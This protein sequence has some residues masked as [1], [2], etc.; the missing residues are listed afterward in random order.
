MAPTPNPFPPHQTTLAQ[1]TVLNGLLRL[2]VE[3]MVLEDLLARALD[4]ILAIP[5]LPLNPT[6]AIFLTGEEPDILELAVERNLPPELKNRCSRVPF[7]HCLCGRAAAMRTTQFAACIDHRHETTYPGIFPHGHY[8]LPLLQGERLLGVLTLYLPEGHIP[9]E[10]E[11][12]FLEAVANAVAKLIAHVRVEEELVAAMERA[13][14]ASRTRSAFL[15]V[16]T[17]EIRTPLNGVLGMLDLLLH[18]DLTGDQAD[19]VRVARN[20]ATTLLTLLDDCLA[21]ARAKGERVESRRCTFDPIEVVATALEVVAPVAMEKELSLAA[22]AAG[23]LPKTVVGDGARLRQLLIHLLSNAVKFT[24]RRDEVVVELECRHVSGDI[25]LEVAVRDTG[26]GM[27]PDRIPHLFE[28]FVQADSSSTRRHGGSGLGLALCHTLVAQMGGKIGV[29]S[30]LG[31]GTTIRCS[32]PVAHPTPPVPVPPRLHAAS[33]LV[34]PATS[35]TTTM[36]V[37]QLRRWGVTVVWASSLERALMVVEQGGRIGR[38]TTILIVDRDHTPDLMSLYTGLAALPAASRPVVLEIG[39]AG[40]AARSMEPPPDL[41]LQ[42]LQKPLQPVVLHRSLA[43]LLDGWENVVP[44]PTAAED[45]ASSESARI[46]VAE[47]NQ[48][49]QQVL[50]HLVRQLGHEVVVVSNGAEAVAAVADGGI[51]LVLMDH[52]MPVMAG[53][54]A[55]ARIRATEPPGRRT[56]IIAVT[57]TALAETRETCLAAGMDDYLVKP[58]HREQLAACLGQWLPRGNPLADRCDTVG[59]RGGHTTAVAD[60]GSTAHRMIDDG[61][62]SEDGK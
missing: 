30:S 7:D 11:C 38:P 60:G 41:V 20:S 25:Q 46:L 57:A 16:M 61:R 21:L 59:A 62:G 52:Q 53:D 58:I 24:E 45:E 18:S 34:I 29:E 43:G 35:P 39:W 48:V 15:E 54:E 37:E 31:E 44:R 28:P 27:S 49:N 33:I 23:D 4:E 9:A 2:G 55:A 22:L 51:D 6:G 36:M 3:P 19:H 42:R 50:V 56:P 10:G 26:I 5:W 8:N 14:A 13:H 47:D 17:H 32:I 12:A 40:A 1:Q